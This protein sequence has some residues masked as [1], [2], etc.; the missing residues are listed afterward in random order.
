[1]AHPLAV[2]KRILF[3]LSLLLLTA[4][5]ATSQTPAQRNTTSDPL[6]WSKYT[7]KG[8]EFSVI[9]PTLPAMTTF[10]AFQPR[11]RK[12]RRER[13]LKTSLG[14][15]V[16]SIDVF[17]NPSPKQSLDDFIAE[18][19][20]NTD[21]DPATER[22]LTVNGVSGKEYSSRNKTLPGVAQFFFTEKRL[23]RFATTGSGAAGPAAKQFFSSIVFDKKPTG[24]RITDGPGLPLEDDIGGTIYKGKD[25]DVKVKM[26]KKPNPEYTER[27]R[28]SMTTG[29]VVLRAVFAWSGRVERITV[30]SGLPDG[31][32]ER[33]IEA[34]QRIRFI[35]AMKDGKPVSMWMM[36]VYN[37]NLY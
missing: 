29:T 13:H 32:T 34:A 14:G 28:S 31:L 25:V 3:L 26:L 24:I 15:V 7:I 1:M 17:E 4:D 30:V 27:A 9:L 2:R 12:E 18:Q 22:S 8:E 20:A 21:Y 10:K 37:F 16:Y 36:L 33:A 23:L 11:L 35:P 5:G 19:Q 6:S